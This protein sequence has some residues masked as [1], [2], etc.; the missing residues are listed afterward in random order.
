M[1]IGIIGG[2]NMG[3]ALYKGLSRSGEYD[4]KDFIISEINEKT[5]DNI[6]ANYNLEITN[7]NNYL[8]ENSDII[9]LAVTPNMIETVL[10]EIDRRLNSEK[11]IVSFAAGMEIARLASYVTDKSVKIVR[12]MPNIPLSIGKGMTS[13]AFNENCT[14]EDKDN[15]FKIFNSCGIVKELEERLFN[16]MTAL[17]GSGPALIFVFL[18]ALADGAVKC[19]LSRDDAYLAAAQV[20]NGSSNLYLESRTHPGVLKD[21]VCSPGGTAIE[22]ITTL[23]KNAFRYA[24]IDAI[25]KCAEKAGKM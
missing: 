12:T 8:V 19:G 10:T 18:E 3:L 14:E 4:D 24:V 15:V 5:F 23:E 1:K 2:G 9:V 6:K 25:E 21:N 13:V 17:T 22:A 7:D 16:L 11:L 20:M